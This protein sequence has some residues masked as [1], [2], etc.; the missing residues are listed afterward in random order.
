M[1]VEEDVMTNQCVQEVFSGRIGTPYH[2]NSPFAE[3]RARYLAHLREQGWAWETVI[4]TACKLAAFAARV[5]IICEGGVTVAQIEAAAED[6]LKHSSHN[7]RTDIGPHR[8]RTKFLSD[9]QNWLRFL[10]RLREPEGALVPYA[11]LVTE[12]TDFL[13]QERG[14]SPATIRRRHCDTLGFLAWFAQQHRPFSEVTVRDVERFLA[15]PRSRRWSRVTIAGCV[16]SLRSFFRYAGIRKWCAPNIAEAIDAPRLYTLAGLPAG[17]SWTQVRQL[18]TG[19]GQQQPADIRNRAIIML[20]A[21]YGFRS[22]E[23]CR[24]RLDDLDWQRELILLSRTK[25]RREHQYPLVREVGEAILL[26]LRKARPLTDR[27]EVFLRLVPPFEPLTVPGLGSMVLGRLKSLDLKLPHYGPHALRHACASHLLA[28][29]LSL[30]EIGDHL[31]HSD[32]R[33]TRIYAKVDLAGLRE[34]ARFDLG[35]LL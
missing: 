10:D 16:A 9:A 28:H 15:L 17:P 8:A 33:S 6:W 23:V 27:R 29:G 30:K 12:F 2:H 18:I 26:Y 24:L 19:I 4:G 34:V 1:I 7:F 5:N 25:Q 11:D 14:L 32:P 13:D 20:L 22:G 3:E 31:G 21:V 35:G